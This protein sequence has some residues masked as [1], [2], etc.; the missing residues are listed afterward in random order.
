[1]LNGNKYLSRGFFTKLDGSLGVSVMIHRIVAFVFVPNPFPKEFNLVN[2]IDLNKDNFKKENLEW[3]DIRWNNQSKNRKQIVTSVY[4]LSTDLEGNQEILRGIKYRP[5]AKNIRKAAETGKIFKDKYWKRIDINLEDYLSKHPIVKDG[6]FKNKFIKGHTVE[7]NVCGILR[8]D[9]KLRIG[10]FT[11]DKFYYVIRISG[12]R[13][14][15]H[16]LIYETI[17]GKQIP[18]GYVID[19]IMPTNKYNINN[20]FSNLRLVTQS[21]NMNNERTVSKIRKAVKRLDFFGNIMQTYNSSMDASKRLNIRRSHIDEAARGD[22]LCVNNSIWVREK[23]ESLVESKLRFIY[24]KFNFNKEAIDA[25]IN[26]GNINT[27]LN[28]ITVKK[29]LNTGVPAPDGFFYQQGDPKHMIYDPN[30][31]ELIKKRPRLY[32]HKKS[33]QDRLSITT[34]KN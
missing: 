25:N 1:M 5:D 3:C 13:Y 12:K 2:H 31:K 30:N 27:K 29:Y 34:L 28:Y 20:E 26:L 18:D 17:S 21:E 6:W 4:Y 8:I 32:F 23:E 22:L 10:T 33:N 24:Y 9:G 19:H 14:L 15:V 11:Y 7:A 16:R